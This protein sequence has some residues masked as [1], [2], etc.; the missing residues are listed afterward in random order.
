MSRTTRNS[1]SIYH[2]NCCYRRPHTFYTIKWIIAS[3]DE[4]KDYGLS[5]RNRSKCWRKYPTAWDDIPIAAF[6][7]TKHTWRNYD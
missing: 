1:Y 6:E 3:V 2:Y 5:L 4:V 7:E